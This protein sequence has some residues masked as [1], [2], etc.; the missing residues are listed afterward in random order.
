[1]ED[2]FK[3]QSEIITDVL[4]K[5]HKEQEGLVIDK[6]SKAQAKLFTDECF[7]LL[8][9]TSL[10][11]NRC[12]TQDEA[13]IYNLNNLLMMMLLPVKKDLNKTIDEIR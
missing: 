3:L 10:Q 13:H 9:P 6:P 2:N 1:M 11:K 12:Y 5:L 8:F 4:S 7:N